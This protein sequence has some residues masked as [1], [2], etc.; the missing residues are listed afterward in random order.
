MTDSIWGASP[1]PLPSVLLLEYWKPVLGYEGWYEVSNMGNVLRVATRYGSPAQRRLS[2]EYHSNGYVRVPITLQG[3]SRHMRVH[4]LV[5][6]AFVGAKPHGYQINHKN[7]DK[8]NNRLSN[9]EYVTPSDNMKH[10]IAGGMAKPP[11]QVAVNRNGRSFKLTRAQVDYIRQQ[12][13][14]VSGVSL[15]KMFGL[16]TGHVS[17]IRNHKCRVPEA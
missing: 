7:F 3:N 14:S 16:S 4:V 17:D 15:A 11:S 8:R 5:M 1:F 12:P 13:R 6:A 10:A 9:L 2:L